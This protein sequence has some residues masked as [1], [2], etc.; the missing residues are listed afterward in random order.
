MIKLFGTLNPIIMA[1]IAGVF[2]WI[3]TS[4]GSAIVILFKKVNKNIMDILLSLS[5]GIMLA[6]SFFS[7]LNPAIEIA[8]ELKQNLLL[9]VFG[10]FLLGGLFIYLCNKL[11]ESFPNNFINKSSFK[12]CFL[13]MT[14]ITIHNIPEGLAVGVA[15]GAILSGASLINALSLTLGI[16][17]Q[18][19]PEGSAISLPLRRDGFSRKKSFLFGVLSGTVE[20][21]SALVGALLVLK[22][23]IILPIVLSFAA[24]AM[25]YVTVVEL[26][27]ESQA[28]KKKGLMALILLLG[29]A[30]MMLLELL[31][32]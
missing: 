1:L 2:C 6:A 9:V 7:L 22:I 28:N 19:F 15:Y 32:G 8:L 21:I 11:I 14:S 20:P 25:L 5:A 10:G 23:R 27:P 3:V 13:L 24:G 31:L 12:R 29:F 18:N 4:L 30:F 17:I 16:A 26:I